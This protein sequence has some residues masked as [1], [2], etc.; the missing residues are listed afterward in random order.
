MLHVK[1]CVNRNNFIR[2]SVAE[3]TAP[4]ASFILLEIDPGVL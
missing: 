2:F 3:L 1:A 4:A